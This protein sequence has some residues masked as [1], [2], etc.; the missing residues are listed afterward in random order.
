MTSHIRSFVKRVLIEMEGRS[1]MT[2][3]DQTMPDIWRGRDVRYYHDL[4]SDCYHLTMTDLDG[5]MIEKEFPDE[6]EAVHWARSKV[7]MSAGEDQT[8]KSE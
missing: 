6:A 1:M 8:K 4:D 5:S 2:P 3:H 7:L